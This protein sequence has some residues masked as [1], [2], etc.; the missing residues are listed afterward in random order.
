MKNERNKS[1]V[2]AALY[3]TDGMLKEFDATVLACEQ[4]D[5]VAGDGKQGSILYGIV[6]DRTA[7]FP[8]GGGQ[9]ADSGH[10]YIGDASDIKEI[11]VVDVRTS[12]DGMIIHYSDEPLAV[13]TKV[14]G[15]IDF[16]T[17][18]RR[19]QNHGAEHIV[20]GLIHK[21]FGYDNV[22][23]HMSET[24]VRFDVNGLIS[25]EEL[26]EIEKKAN[27][28]VYQNMPITIEY[29]SADEAKK[30]DYRSKLD[31]T[32]GIRI[33]NIGDVDSCACCAP[34]LPSTG[35]IGII[36]IIDSMPHRQGTRITM[37]AGANA[38][39][40]YCM[41][42]TANA[43]IM[44]LLS[45]KREETAQFANDFMERYKKL[46]EENGALKTEVTKM[47]SD[48]VTRGLKERAKDDLTPEIIF[49]NA[50]DNIGLR[51]L[52][53]NCTEIFDGVVAGFIGD[54]TEGYKYIIGN[55]ANNDIV[56]IT[57][58]LNQR[59]G[60][61]GGGNNQMTQGSITASESEIR[62]Y[63]IANVQKSL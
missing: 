42:H 27:E 58:S 46:A 48:G 30:L 26:A 62:S 12:E 10:L 50:L 11:D 16:D 28:A 31:I 20:S 60:G 23:Y 34:H 51:N 17:R 44:Y 35:M 52:V 19:M 57:K 9:Q 18:F 63:L 8:E 45:A 47:I 24:T 7:F 38:Y 41:L 29:P 2:T 25:R 1:D 43:Q 40:D 39:D 6:L 61:R 32:E 36:K 22:G 37:I 15:V 13:G 49:T 55:S 14:R 33:V 5:K 54:D 3:E 53:N 21:S 59:F 56:S 4:D